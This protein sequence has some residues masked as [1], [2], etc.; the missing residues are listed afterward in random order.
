[1]RV[2]HICYGNLSGG[3]SKGAYNLHLA[4]LDE[5]VDSN[6]ICSHR[7]GIGETASVDYLAKTNSTKFL[8]R[9]FRKLNHLASRGEPESKWLFS[10]DKFAYV[11]DLS[12]LCKNSD[13]INL[14]WINGGFVSPY[15]LL[16]IKQPVVWTFRDMWPFTGGCHYSMNCDNYVQG[17]GNCPHFSGSDKR[18]KARR[19]FER[20]ESIVSNKS[21][22][23]GVGISP[24]ITESARRSAI[25]S[26]SNL[27]TI[28]NGV[29]VEQFP[30]VRR[31]SAIRR[32]GLSEDYNYISF[33]ALN[34]SLGYK[35]SEKFIEVLNLTE[36]DPD[37]AKVKFLVFGDSK[38]LLR[39]NEGGRVID[40]GLVKDQNKLNLIYAASSGF[41]ATSIQ[42]AFGK[43][44][45]ESLS[46]GTPVVTFRTSAFI[47]MFNHMVQ[48][49]HAESFSSSSLIEG[50]KWC[51]GLARNK[52]EADYEELRKVISRYAGRFDSV[53]CAKSYKSLYEEIASKDT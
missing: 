22:L 29:R 5:G 48:G 44:I 33:G 6:F 34:H 42:E 46:S 40:F 43:T 28:W 18:F 24:W 9:V 26:N 32:L 1:M 3:A 38:A 52:N 30:Y 8:F 13:V 21:N 25:W 39:G 31:S 2:S 12:N 20:K 15:S 19:Q 35:G 17:C 37:F 16:R 11:R 14:H 27:R 51:I 23:Y 47:D 7:P 45:V 50:M 4:L 36:Q 41:L 49:F 53:K 10:S